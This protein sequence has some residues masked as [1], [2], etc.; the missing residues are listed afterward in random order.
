MMQGTTN[1]KFKNGMISHVTAL[2][3]ANNC[4]LLVQAGMSSG[5]VMIGP[6]VKHPGNP[7][8]VCDNNS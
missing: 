2:V 8:F 1:I 5:S 3:W 6:R 7:E 4:M